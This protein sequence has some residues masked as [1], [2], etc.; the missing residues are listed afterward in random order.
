MQ[1]VRLNAWD[2][3]AFDWTTGVSPL[4]GLLIPWKRFPQLS[5]VAISL[6]TTLDVALEGYEHLALVARDAGGLATM[7]AVLDDDVARARLAALVLLGVPFR[8]LKTYW[9][10]PTYRLHVQLRDLAAG[11]EFIARLGADWTEKIGENPPF[12]LRAVHGESEAAVFPSE[13]TLG[14]FPSRFRDVIGSS[15]T[16][17]DDADDA[18]YT[19]VSSLLAD[20]PCGGPV[21]VSYAH[22]DRPIVERIR[23][24]LEGSGVDTWVD[25]HD[26]RPGDKWLLE[27]DQ[28]VDSASA[29]LF[30]VSSNSLEAIERDRF[31]KRELQDCLEATSRRRRP[32]IPVVVGETPLPPQLTKYQWVDIDDPHGMESL[33]AALRE[34]VPPAGSG[35]RTTQ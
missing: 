26:L 17:P 34:H 10:Y 33:V 4:A 21:F 12:L 22:E 11:S 18:T 3:F 13:T 28:A 2:V 7:R 5:T 32:L 24:H 29:V 16:S 1:D 20:Q 27:L 15:H 23:S 25:Q 6:S 14:G 30:V 19:F 35:T 9:W 31:L 8:G